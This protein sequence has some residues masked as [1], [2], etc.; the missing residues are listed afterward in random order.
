MDR[1]IANNNKN[2]IYSLAKDDEAEAILKE[3]ELQYI[4][5]YPDSAYIP[6]KD[7]RISDPVWLKR[8]AR[9]NNYDVF[10]AKSTE[11]LDKLYDSCSG[12]NSLFITGH[13]NSNCIMCP[14][15]E[16]ARKNG[17]HYSTEELLEIIHHIIDYPA[18][19]TITGGEPFLLG[20]GIFPVL[21]ELKTRFPDGEYLLLTNGRIFSNKTFCSLLQDNLPQKSMIGIPLHGYN[22]TTHDRI[23]QTPD[24]FRQ[25]FLGLK[26]L[27]SMD[28]CIELRIVVSGLN[29]AFI[30]QIADL[31]ISE[32][33]SVSYVRIMGLEML[34]N[35]ALHRKEVWIP[36]LDAFLASRNAVNKLIHHGIDTSLYNFPL[37]SV[38]KKYWMICPRSI[39]GYKIRYAEICDE[40]DV[41]EACG[42]IF[43]GS[44]SYAK[45]D[46]NPI[47][48]NAL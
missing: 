1:T 24:S 38:D 29:A 42:G 13:C 5:L 18:H 47:H 16:H 10:L 11:K 45:S 31:I 8:F 17:D 27:L 30:D 48:E 15:S 22:P 46:V 14:S 43:G 35:A 33:R 9:S 6:A 26:H 7:E 23:T 40:C 2:D 21:N 36:Y 32:F 41:K 28:F 39:S 25:T 37:C 34:G 20:K 19:L 44:F 12:D 3:K 4:R